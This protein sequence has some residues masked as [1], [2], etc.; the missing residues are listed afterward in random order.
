MPIIELNLIWNYI[1]PDIIY[2]YAL[3]I[4]MHIVYTTYMHI[5]K[6]HYYLFY[7]QNNLGINLAMTILTFFLY[8]V[9]LNAVPDQVVEVVTECTQD[10]G[11]LPKGNYM[12]P[13]QY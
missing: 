13:V 5:R 8:N 11:E 9:I 4:C 3:Y 1:L 7:T 6:V 12:P 10:Y 2:M